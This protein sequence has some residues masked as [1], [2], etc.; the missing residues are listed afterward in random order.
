MPLL[1]EKLGEDT[2]QLSMRFGL[3]VSD[4]VS[5]R[6]VVV[7]LLNEP[8]LTAFTLAVGTSYRGS[9]ARRKSPFSVVWRHGKHSGPDG[10]ERPTRENPRV[11]GDS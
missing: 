6:L 2:A 1:V 4:S 8:I 11:S 9:F 5:K 3:H 10:I 7:R